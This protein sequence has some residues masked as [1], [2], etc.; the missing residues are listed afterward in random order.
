MFCAGAVNDFMDKNCPYI[1]GAI[2]FYMLF[3]MFPLFLAIVSILSYVLGSRADEEQLRLAQNVAAI[4]P[5][6]SEYVSDTMLGVISARALSGIAA[7]FGLLWAATAAFGAIRKGIN[8]AWGIKTTRPFFE[9]RLIDFALV[10]GAGVV[11][12]AVLFSVPAL[13]ILREI[14]KVLAPETDAFGEFIWRLPALLLYPSLSFLTFLILY[15]FLPNTDVRLKDVWAWALLASLAFD[16][17]NLG[18][19][20]YV[21]SFALDHYNLVYGSVSAILALLTWVYLSAIIVL[22]GALVAS[23]YVSYASSME[24][25][26]HKLRLL[27]TGFSR[28]SLRVVES[29]RVG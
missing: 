8:T 5:V 22:F 13:E 28:V 11:L 15:R 19:V 20:W 23:R 3:A 29:T 21:K 6:S 12:M 9:E 25:E 1:A 10:L 17:V 2:S 26:E 27:L 4:L 16:A 7:I 14:A 24:T 18:F